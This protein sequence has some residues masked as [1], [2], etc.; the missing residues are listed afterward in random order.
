MNLKF[1]VQQFHCKFMELCLKLLWLTDKQTL[2]YFVLSYIGNPH[3]AEKGNWVLFSKKQMHL[4]K[5]ESSGTLE[6]KFEDL[7]FEKWKD[8]F[9]RFHLK[10]FFLL[11]FQGQKYGIKG[12]KT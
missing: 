10:S 8:G 11:D 4:E 9:F 6:L 1:L 7:L 2:E 12:Q 5:K 3:L